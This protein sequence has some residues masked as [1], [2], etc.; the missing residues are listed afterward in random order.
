MQH[1]K[2]TLST[3]HRWNSLW[4]RGVDV[5]STESKVPGLQ[6]SFTRHSAKTPFCHEQLVLVQSFGCSAL[7]MR[8]QAGA[9]K[10]APLFC[11]CCCQM[12]SHQRAICN[13]NL[14][15]KDVITG[16]AMLPHGQP[17]PSPQCQ[18]HTWHHTAPSQ[19]MVRQ[20]SAA[21]VNSPTPILHRWRCISHVTNC[22]K[23]CTA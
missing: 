21:A 17:K 10:S 5:L 16:E 14:G 18:T 7:L 3:T 6:S 9:R 2:D 19:H 4:H 15:S 23:R 22:C 12:V 1:T 13:D 11:T 8:M 20:Q